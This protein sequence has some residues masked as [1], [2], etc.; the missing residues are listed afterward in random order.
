MDLERDEFVIKYDASL[1][2]DAE[3][4]AASDMLHSWNRQS[5]DDDGDGTYDEA[6]TGLFRAFVA[7]LLQR[8]LSDDLGDVYGYFATT[9]YPT[10]ATP[11][12]A[13]TNLT[14]GL[15][16]IIAAI[17]GEGGFDIFNGQTPEVVVARA[18][19]GAIQT[20]EADGLAVAARPFLTR[21]FLGI[22]QA[23][24]TE[25]LTA[26]LEQNRGTENN[27]I[28]MRPGAIV[29]W[30]VTPPGQSGFIGQNGSKSPHYDDQFELYYQFGRKRTWF[31]PEDV[32]ANK[33]SETVLTYSP[34]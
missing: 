22:P 31:Y 16:A 14:S 20:G 9:G 11:T 26:P 7:E 3:L 27:M 34:L 17:D 6:A 21:N 23:A 30:E 8:T 19:R 29:G 10:A 13:G 25:E 5:R 15:K 12:S 32:E 1:A 18:L 24:E 28:V 33:V 2:S 4:I